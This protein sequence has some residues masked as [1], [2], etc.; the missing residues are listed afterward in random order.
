MDSAVHLTAAGASG[1]GGQ[2]DLHREAP[3]AALEV[4]LG[5]HSHGFHGVIALIQDYQIAV[6]YCL[7]RRACPVLLPMQHLSIYLVKTYCRVP[8]FSVYLEF[9]H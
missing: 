4:L 1:E 5:V 3:K 9:Q 7:G 8:L 2:A 6:C